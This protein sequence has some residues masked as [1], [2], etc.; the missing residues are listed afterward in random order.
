MKDKSQIKALFKEK[1]C[2]VLIPTYNNAQ[3]LKEVI[4]DVQQY[5]DELIVVNDGS[6]DNT[7]DI[8]ADF[9]DVDLVSY[10][11]N[12]GKGFALRTGFEH[13]VQQ[14]YEYAVTMDSDGQHLAS[15]LPVFLEKLEES[16][17]AIIIGSRRMDQESV[18]DKSN[19]G[20]KFSNFW[21]RVETGIDLP[22]TQ[23][24]YRLYPVKAL[25]G[26]KFFS[27]KYEFE[28][29]VI[30]RA[31]WKGIEVTEVPVDVFYPE[32]EKRITHFRPFWDFFRISVLNTILMTLTSAYFKP[33]D[34]IRS[35]KN[36]TFKGVIRDEILGG[37]EPT[38]MIAVAIGFGIFMGIVPIWGYQLLVGFTIAHLFKI[39]KAIFFIAANI[40]IPPMIPFILYLSYIIG[41]M[42][43][44]EFSWAV[45]MDV[46][47]DVVKENLQQYIVGSMILASLGGLLIGFMS[48]LILLMVKKK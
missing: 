23:S 25:S 43:M 46:T 38:H 42:A 8:L 41:G 4:L 34:I 9:T 30:V 27:N 33:R 12:K 20:R 19:F 28:I 29:E 47:W 32:E 31:A 14:G 24:G 22:D 17:N 16:P 7:T 11:K 3:V 45:N 37:N 44:G 5:C 10:P 2:C 39:N 15:D 35:Y 26:M 40:S 1:K 21:F 6:T 48:Y 18:P 13:A 36:K